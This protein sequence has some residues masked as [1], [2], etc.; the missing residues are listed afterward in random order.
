MRVATWNVNGVRARAAQ[1][2][3][4][5]AEARPEV[6]CLQETKARPDQLAPSLCDLDGYHC[7]WHPAPK[8]Y[9]GVA[10]H[11]RRDWAQAV[12]FFH[13]PHDMESRLVCARVG[14]VV[15]ASLYMPNGGKDYAAK[16][17]FMHAMIDWVRAVHAAGD[18][19]VLAGDMNVA[20]APLDVH[21]KLQ[22]P[23][24]VGQSAEERGLFADMLVGLVDAGRHLHPADDRL[25]T[26]WPYWRESRQRNI[27]WRLDYVLISE[28]LLPR[29]TRCELMRDLG[30]SDH[31][32]VVATLELGG[33]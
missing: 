31:C 8:G 27:G 17:A 21:P 4:W 10:L 23:T 32:P 25:F 29:L 13:P 30:T 11:V 7:L 16:I 15:F 14:R 1:L 12:E 6:V 18:Q 5:L 22:D 19:L 9:S 28:A 33:D 26:W 3:G 24:V 20:R 2:V